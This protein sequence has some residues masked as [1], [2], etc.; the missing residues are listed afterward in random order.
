MNPTDEELDR[1]WQ[2]NGRRPQSTIARSFSAELMDIFRIENSVA[3]LD[4]QLNKRKEKVTTHTSELEALEK[5]IK[6]MEDRLKRSSGSGQAAT[7][8]PGSQRRA[9]ANAVAAADKDLA[10]QRSMGTSRP[11]TA[12]QPQQ[13]PAHGGAMP[14]TPTASEGEYELVDPSTAF[15]F[16][17]SHHY[18]SN[19]LATQSFTDMVLVY[20]DGDR[21]S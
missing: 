11:G 1:D 8:A 9:A 14:P 4:E 20:K 15:A 3:D 6:E 5:R 13:A 21:D 16:P 10:A 12:K 7:A 2:P 19:G 18:G 17:Q